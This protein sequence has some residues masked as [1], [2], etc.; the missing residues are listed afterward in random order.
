MLKQHAHAHVHP[1]LLGSARVVEIDAKDPHGAGLF[2]VQP[3]D[4]AQQNGLAG[5]RRPDEAEDLAPANVQIEIFQHGRVVEGD[6][7]AACLDD[8]LLRLADGLRGPAFSNHILH[9]RHH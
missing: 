9:R 7:D 3:Q 2:L 5:T 1:H 4:R 6:G 8:D